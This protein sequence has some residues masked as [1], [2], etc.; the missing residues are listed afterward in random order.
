MTI[1]DPQGYKITRIRIG[2]LP[3]AKPRL[4]ENIELI[5]QRDGAYP[6]P[7]DDE[8]NYWADVIQE[9]ARFYYR[10]GDTLVG[11]DWD[12]HRTVIAHPFLHYFSAA[13]K[14]HLRTRRARERARNAG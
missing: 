5:G 2:L 14:L 9:G 7:R 13:L 1:N 4:R 11:I 12:E 8:H 10:V 6:F 3:T